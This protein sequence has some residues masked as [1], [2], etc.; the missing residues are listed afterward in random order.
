MQRLYIIKAGTTF[1]DTRVKLG[2]FDD[3]TLAALGETVTLTRILDMERGAALPAAADCAGV[4]ITGAHTM[5]TDDHP[6]SVV[7][8]KW[9]PSLLSAGTPL[10]GICYGHQLMARAAG[11]KV[12]LHLQGQEISTVTVKQLAV[13][14]QDIL[15][16]H[17]PPSFPAHVT[18]L[19][20][21]LALPPGAT[22]LAANSHEPNHAFRIGACAWGVQFNPEFTA[23]IMRAYIREQ[24]PAL[25]AAGM[26]I[27]HLLQAVSQTP[28]AGSMLREFAR[29]VEGQPC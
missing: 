22:R 24:A 2:D 21:V 6:W 7:L 15:F 12:G 13:A 5:V 28:E 8:E 29:V 27:E 14:E 1:P 9:I 18:H 17:L 25:T 3:W 11:G 10:F 19:Q 16:K 26:E 20:T 23:E 4:V